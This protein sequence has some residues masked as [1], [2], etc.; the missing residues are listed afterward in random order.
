MENPFYEILTSAF[1][2]EGKDQSLESLTEKVE[3]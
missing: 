3:I 1:L 2:Y